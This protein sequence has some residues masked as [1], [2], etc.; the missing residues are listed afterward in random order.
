MIRYHATVT[1][2]SVRHRYS[3]RTSKTNL[4]ITKYKANGIKGMHKS[5]KDRRKDSSCIKA[6]S[7][8][9]EQ[10]WTRAR[11]RSYSSGWRPI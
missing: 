7:H 11:H 5:L 9:G 8:A 4:I 1:R 6:D 2:Y 3:A 10:V